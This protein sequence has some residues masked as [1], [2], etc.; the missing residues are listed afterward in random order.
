MS[1]YEIILFDMDGTTA[2]TDEMIFHTFFDLYDKYNPSGRKEKEELIYFSGPPLKE[3]M[4][5]EFPNYD[6]DFMISEF[7][8]ISK[9]YYDQYVVPF[10]GEIE[11]LTKFKRAGYKMAVVTNKGTEMA[12]YVLKILKID[13][14]IDFVIGSND[15]VR[16]KPHQEGIEKAIA[17]YNVS[18]DKV[19]YV[20][21]N[22]ID[23]MTANNADVDCMICDWG[24]RKLTVLDKCKYVVHS[25]KDMEDILL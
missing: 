7:L 8:R 13:H 14:L 12:Y 19:L 20:G 5:K 1:K 6:T 21:D 16:F 17:K 23:Y 4:P 15:V 3:T 22:D 10:E 11:A 25:Y 9:P 24:P 18:K 2:Y